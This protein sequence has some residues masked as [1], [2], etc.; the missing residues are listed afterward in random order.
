MN[1]KKRFFG[2]TALASAVIAMSALAATSAQADVPAADLS[3]NA[4]STY[5]VVKGDTLWDISGKFLKKPWLW[6]S[7]WEPNK[8]AIKD[9]HWIYPGDVL[10][11][12]VENGRARLSRTKAK[13]LGEVRLKPGIRFEDA[14]SAEDSAINT[15]SY[16]SIKHF[17]T[18]PVLVTKEQMQSAPRIL[19][20]ADGRE[21]VGNGYKAYVT[22]LESAE[23]DASYAIYRSGPAIVDPD[24]KQVLAYEALF[25]GE[26]DVVKAGRIST[27]KIN[28]ANQEITKGDRL[29]KIEKDADLS[30]ILQPAPENFQGRIVRIFDGQSSS[31]MAQTGMDPRT[32]DKEGGPLSVVILNKGANAGL[33]AGQAIQL[34]SAGQKVGRESLIGFYNGNRA[35]APVTLPPEHN[36]EAVVFKVFEN[37]S[38][39]LVLSA[40]RSVLA[41]DHVSAP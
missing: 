10:Y 29:V 32:Y 24:T 38:Y 3:S 8:Q 19:S 28:G 31:L 30:K 21:F 35:E 17:L 6:P 41:G 40:Q 11:L 36:G 34:T 1:S 9:P 22:G 27:L 37:V 2:K 25:V 14:A 18:R 16:K 5:T 23:S 4:P 20:G 12:H 13:T 39:A 15:I 26:A 7:I 33:E